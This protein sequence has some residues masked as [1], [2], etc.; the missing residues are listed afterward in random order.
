[1]KKILTIII[2]MIALTSLALSSNE[3]FTTK[4]V[5]FSK[6]Q[7]L[8]K[9]EAFFGEYSEYTETLSK[10]RSTVVSRGIETA[11]NILPN[12]SSKLLNALTKNG[13]AD[14]IGN[15][16]LGIGINFIYSQLDKLA[17]DQIF[18]KL[19]V[20]TLKNGTTAME[21]KILISDKNPKLSI[22][23]IKQLLN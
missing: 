16:G 10:I 1:M 8:T 3:T 11:L 18:I 2:T 15:I 23:Q 22:K 21:S 5:P 4:S 6:S 19:T 13:G 17:D 9:T 20:V 12:D 7:V 14:F